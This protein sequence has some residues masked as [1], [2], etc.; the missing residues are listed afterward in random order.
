MLQL[1]LNTFLKR[2]YLDRLTKAALDPRF[3]FIEF[4]DA[5]IQIRFRGDVV[6]RSMKW[7]FKVS[8]GH[9]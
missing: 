3:T 6:H 5:E 7:E 2:I 8:R 4:E 1:S 9:V